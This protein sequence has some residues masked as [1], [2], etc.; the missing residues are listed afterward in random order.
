MIH[1]ILGEL[2]DAA[3]RGVLWL[4]TFAVLW[5]GCMAV[6]KRTPEWLELAGVLK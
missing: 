6:I 2:L 1:Q 3:W 4:V 5:V